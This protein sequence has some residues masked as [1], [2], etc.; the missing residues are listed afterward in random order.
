MILSIYRNKNLLSLIF[1]MIHEF[2]LNT[3]PKLIESKT[4]QL[5][6]F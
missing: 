1:E 3:K 6:E 5:S 2:Q 4:Q